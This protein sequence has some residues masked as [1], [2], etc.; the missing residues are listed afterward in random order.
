M[1]GLRFFPLKSADV[2]GAGTRDEPLRTSAWEAID[3]RVNFK[4]YFDRWINFTL[5][6][7]SWKI[8]QGLEKTT[9][10]SR[11]ILVVSCETW[12]WAALL[13]DGPRDYFCEAVVCGK[14]TAFWEAKQ[15]EDEDYVFYLDD[16]KR[17]SRRCPPNTRYTTTTIDMGFWLLSLLTFYMMF[18]GLFYSWQWKTWSKAPTDWASIWFFFSSCLTHWEVM[19]LGLTHIDFLWSLFDLCYRVR[20]SIFDL[21]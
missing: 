1:I 7:L 17:F 6:Y 13:V 2:R 19:K 20:F 14:M 11:G 4:C 12:R 9:G 10:H 21:F 18:L 3:G 15:L 5:E 16:I 8:F